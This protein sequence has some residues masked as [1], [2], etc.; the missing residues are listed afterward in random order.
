MLVVESPDGIPKDPIDAKAT[1]L[2]GWEV[3]DAS[4][5]E[6]EALAGAGYRLED[7]QQDA[8]EGGRERD[9]MA[10]K[11]NGQQRAGSGDPRAAADRPKMERYQQVTFHVPRTTLTALHR[12]FAERKTEALLAGDPRPT[13]SAIVDAAI[14]AAIASARQNPRPAG[15]KRR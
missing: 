4:L 15:R 2:A 13:L 6:R 7:S 14:L 1:D 5:A 10:R 12:H 3:A 11:G 9:P 8:T